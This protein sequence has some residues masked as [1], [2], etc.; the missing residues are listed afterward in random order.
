MLN[1][2]QSPIEDAE[3][4]DFLQHKPIH[5]RAALDKVDAYSGASYVV[6]ANPTN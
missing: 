3:I 5:F 1:L 4:Q 2:K 6:I